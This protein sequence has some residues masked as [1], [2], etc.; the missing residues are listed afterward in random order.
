MA[1]VQLENKVGDLPPEI[2]KP[3]D[4]K[5]DAQWLSEHPE[6]VKAL[7][8]VVKAEML[9]LFEPEAAEMIAKARE[10]VDRTKVVRSLLSGEGETSVVPTGRPKMTKEQ[11]AEWLSCRIRRMGN[12]GDGIPNPDLDADGIITQALGP[13]VGSA[14]GYAIPDDF[15]A[16]IARRNEEPS[17]VWPMLTKFPTNRTSVTQPVITA[18]PSV[19][20][21][22]AALSS[23]VTST[24]EIAETEPTMDELTWTM[25]Y[26]DARLLVKLDLLTDSPMNIYEQLLQVVADAFMTERERE[27]IIGT[28]AANS[29][30]EGILT[31]GGITEVAI[32]AALSI[33]TLMNFVENIPQRYRVAG[34][35]QLLMP[36]TIIFELVASLAQNV[37]AAQYL[38]G[39][40]PPFSESAYVTDGKIIGGDF[41]RYI[42]Y[43]NLLMQIVSAVVPGKFAMDIAVIEKWDGQVTIDDAFRIGTGVTYS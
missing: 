27:P 37:R 35:T 10:E 18:Y 30:P 34:R 8:G 16:E 36:T 20:K 1:E 12:W 32:G 2:T 13:T 29:R 15:V 4:G 5:T 28:G 24:D 41:S 33:S 21:G 26:F 19:S 40:L 14:G 42:V 6:V 25:R 3:T 31:G 23:S 43:Y 22:A 9:A 39:F 38:I 7:A 17:I 11:R